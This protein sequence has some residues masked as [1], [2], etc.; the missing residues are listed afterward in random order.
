VRETAARQGRPKVALGVIGVD[1]PRRVVVSFAFRDERKAF[2]VALDLVARSATV[3]RAATE[4][5][6]AVERPGRW[7]PESGIELAD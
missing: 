7:S 3:A 1:L 4:D 2:V 5:R 6:P